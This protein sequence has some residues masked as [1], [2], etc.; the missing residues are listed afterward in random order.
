LNKGIERLNA[1]VDLVK[2]RNAL[3][4]KPCK[5]IISLS[6]SFFLSHSMLSLSSSLFLPFL[7]F[8]SLFFPPLTI[9]PEKF[10]ISNLKNDTAPVLT[11]H[12]FLSGSIYENTTLI[13][14]TVSSE[15]KRGSADHLMHTWW[16]RRQS[17]GGSR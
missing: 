1:V 5:Q 16:K 8:S 3:T 15:G 7:P 6:F 4:L 9:R 10:D 11:V 17:E 12:S 2:Y 14:S 13:N